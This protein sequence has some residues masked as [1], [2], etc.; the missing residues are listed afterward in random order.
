[1]CWMTRILLLQV[2]MNVGLGY[3]SVDV[4]RVWVIGGA[5]MLVGF[6]LGPGDDVG[7]SRAR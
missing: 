4:Q 5:T 3:G 1:M 2:C 7:C 6:Y